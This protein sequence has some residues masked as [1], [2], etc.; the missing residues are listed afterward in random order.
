MQDDTICAISTPIGTGGVSIIRISGDN[1]LGVLK[2]VFVGG[3]SKDFEPRKMYFGEVKFT[4]FSD[5]ALCVF[6]EK[7]N[8]FTGENVVE[9]NLHGGYYLTKTVLDEILKMPKIRLAEPGEFSKRAVMNGKMDMSQAEAVIDMINAS[10]LAELRAGSHILQGALREKVAEIQ[11]KLT[12]LIC[13]VDVAIDYP[14]Q[15]I[16][17]ITHSEVENRLNEVIL[18]LKNLDKTT[19]TGQIIKNGVTVAL[20]GIPNA[21]KSSLLNAMLGYDRAIVTDI[22][23]TTRDSLNESYEFNG[24]K[25]NIVDTAGI[26]NANNEVEKIGIER[27]KQEVLQ[28]DLVLNIVDGTVDYDLQ[29][30]ELPENAKMLKILNKIDEKTLK[31]MENIDFDIKISAKNNVNIMELK[32]L[33]FDKT[34]D[35]NMLNEKILITNVR[36]K[37]CIVDSIKILDEVMLTIKNQMPLD[38][39]ALMLREGWMK[40]GQITGSNTDQVIIDRIFSKFCLGK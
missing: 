30:I 40:I 32:Q 13:E 7:P 8:S 14:D 17:Y 1:A 12:D 4:D 38:C 15:D 10:S 33:I 27:A 11:A 6:F 3:D 22:A 16:E 26:R 34:I 28:A 25:F 2:K 39:V 20:A 19:K 31:N 35:S 21:G 37:Q 9:I 24:V 5:Q 18:D 29:Q 23:G 36:H